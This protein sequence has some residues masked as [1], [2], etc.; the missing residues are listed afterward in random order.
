MRILTAAA[1][2]ACLISTPVL[3]DEFTETLD[4][5]MEAYEDGDI[6][7]A[8]DEL[9]YAALLL[10]EMQGA[11]FTRLLPKALDGWTMEVA[12]D[13]SA[14]MAMFGG[15][16]MAT[17]EYSNGDVSIEIQL[18]ADN[19]LASS[20]VTMLGNTATMGMMG[21]VIRVKREKFLNQDDDIQGVIG[22]V[23]IQITG[24]ASVDEKIEFLEAVDFELLE[25]Y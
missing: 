6:A 25:D 1:I 20:M 8:K 15:G 4:L 22:K 23:F 10:Q 13:D 5:A 11:D 14:A 12:E 3:A 17:A 21:K 2:A 9:D 7:G 18:M 19:P 16:V 24:S